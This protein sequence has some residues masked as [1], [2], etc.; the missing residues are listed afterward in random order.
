MV[1]SVE[2]DVATKIWEGI[3]VG[4]AGGAVAGFII[5]LFQW[6]REKIV[7]REHK[8]RVYNWI[9][10]KTKQPENLTVGDLTIPE[11]ISTLEIASYTNLTPDRVR[12]VC[13]IHDK[14][15]SKTEK[16]RRKYEE[17]LEDKWAIR[18]FVDL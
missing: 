7:E 14:I 8:K 13:S 9:Y 17:V 18:E 1:L 12:H 16:E 10:E 4:G 5:W 11:W 2:V 15:R 6:V 3:A